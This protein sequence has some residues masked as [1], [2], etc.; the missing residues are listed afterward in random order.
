SKQKLSI[1]VFSQ[2]YILLVIA[3]GLA[4][5]G[6]LVPHEA[7]GEGFQIVGPGG[8]G[9]M[10]HATI[11]PHNANEALIACD[12]TGSY[13]THDGGKSWRMFNLRQPANF[14]VF[15]P[16][17]PHTMYAGN[18]GLWR[19]EDDGESWKLVWPRPSTVTGIQM[20]SDH[21]DE[22][23]VSDHNDL[24]TIV[25]LAIDPSDSSMLFAGAVKDRGAQNR[26]E[27]SS[28][29]ALFLSTDGGEKWEQLHD[30][31][32]V[33]T[34]IWVDPHSDRKDR[35]L[36]VGGKWGITVRH[37]G[38]W[39]DR[40]APKGVEFSDVSAGFSDTHGAM[41]YATS[42]AGM[43]LSNV[44][45][46]SW[47]S[48]S[49]PGS[50]A[51]VRAIATSLNHPESAYVSYRQLQ[52]DGKTWMGVARTHDS[53][54]TWKLLWK[55]TKTTSSPNIHDAW[56][57]K[58]LGPDWG[59][60]P[61]GIGVAE[62]NPDMAYGTDYGRTMITTDGGATWDAAYSKKVPGAAWT[63]T[64]LDVTTNYGYL[65]DPFNADRRFIP[66]TD[67]GLFRSEDKGRTWERSMKGVPEAWSNTVYWVVF[68][69]AVRGK[70]WGV[71]SGTH[72]LPR[73]KMWRTR[74]T[75]KYHGGVCISLDGGKTWK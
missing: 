28:S 30:L 16:L 3:L 1:S 22:T 9:A 49:L 25:A 43:F 38:K 17:L 33:P 65:Y 24:G 18:D 55:E 37:F 20:S 41:I 68:D 67:I 75:L 8:G 58:D 62:Q 63:S 70:M 40:S 42:S 53:G 31:P 54:R 51:Q 10:F 11:S 52:L 13:I 39:Q 6:F 44:G 23:I 74:S 35:D 2:R 50:G 46:N 27:M 32:G 12:M 61:L 19:S 66:T 71:M 34:H 15:D 47:V 48:S 29:G 64:G 4:L 56:I 72:D 26:T 59:E 5:V 21:S 14:F 57:S 69:P 60:N 45:G 36:Y 73:P 7:S